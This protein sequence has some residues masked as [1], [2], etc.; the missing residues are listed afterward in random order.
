MEQFNNT[1][2][3]LYVSCYAQKVF[4]NDPASFF[5]E[6]N[7]NLD[8]REALLAIDKKNIKTFG[9]ELFTK[10]LKVVQKH[11]PLLF[12]TQHTIFSKMY[13]AAYELFPQGNRERMLCYLERVGSYFLDSVQYE[14]EY[15]KKLQTYYF[16]LTKYYWIIIK[17]KLTNMPSY[18]VNLKEYNDEYFPL[19]Y[20]NLHLESFNFDP[21]EVITYL[22]DSLAINFA[23]HEEK[24]LQPNFIQCDYL[25]YSM[26]NKMQSFKLNKALAL[27]LSLCNGAYTVNEILKLLVSRFKYTET[28][29]VEIKNNLL[30]DL[31]EKRWIYLNA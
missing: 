3:R 7:L 16:D 19:L 5:E 13:S 27:V 24:K 12:E 1:L 18:T 29:C 9:R 14:I 22:E 30:P 28:E 20:P 26:N 10:R 15:E 11:F 4:W 25:F 17:C 6:L 31:I 8:E 2:S 23:S 21:K